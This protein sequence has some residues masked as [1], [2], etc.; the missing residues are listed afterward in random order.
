MGV[1]LKPDTRIIMGTIN[2]IRT[3]VPAVP[4]SFLALLLL[5][6]LRKQSV[7]THTGNVIKGKRRQN[8]SS[9]FSRLMEKLLIGLLLL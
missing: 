5:K 7:W 4:T 6:M 9:Q 2:S 8:V 3:T 1:R